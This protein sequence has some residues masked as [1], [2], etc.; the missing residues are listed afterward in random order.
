VTFTVQVDVDLG[1]LTAR[2]FHIG[3]DHAP[4]S[5]VIYIPEEGVAFLG[6]CFYPGFIGDDD[7]Y[8][9]ARLF[10]L[11]DRLEALPAEYYVLSH[12]PAPLPRAEFLHEV[13]RLRGIGTLVSELGDQREAILA[14]LPAVLGAPLSED[15]TLDVNSFLRGLKED[16]AQDSKKVEEIK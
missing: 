9:V 15:D 3:G 11:L 10:P 2:I 7:F 8:T 13:T 5:S 16:V 1:D 14:R 6:D 12:N 4:D